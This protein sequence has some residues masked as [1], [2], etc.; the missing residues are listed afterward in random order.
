MP[1]K[2][3]PPTAS[4][5]RVL[6]AAAIWIAGGHV[7]VHAEWTGLEALIEASRSATVEMAPTVVSPELTVKGR[8]P[9]P[10]PRPAPFAA[11]A[12]WPA[13]KPAEVGRTLALPVSGRPLSVQPLDDGR[14]L[15]G[16]STVLLAVAP[17]GA[18][19]AAVVL[20]A[21]ARNV[22]PDQNGERLLVTTTGD[23]PFFVLDARTLKVHSSITGDYGGAV[24]WWGEMSGELLLVRETLDFS[25]QL[26]N[27][28]FTLIETLPESGGEPKPLG[29]PV[30]LFA[31]AG[32]VAPLG[33]FWA[34]PARP[35]QVDP[36]PGPL[37]ALEGT[38]VRGALIEPSPCADTRPAGGRDGRLYWIRT[39]EHGS[40]SGRLMTRDPS[41]G[42]V[43]R[44]LTP[45]ATWLL[46]VSP[47]GNH[48]AW[49]A[50][51]DG[52]AELRLSTA[53]ELA[54]VDSGAVAAADESLA[55]AWRAANRRMADAFAST[56][57]ADDLATTGPTPLLT[58]R[59]TWEDVE[60]MGRA[61]E[62]ALQN[63]FHLTAGERSLLPVGD[64]LL[65][66]SAGLVGDGPIEVLAVGGFVVREAR[67]RGIGT[68]LPAAGSPSLSATE[69]DWAWTDE[70]TMTLASPWVIAR[71][72]LDRKL[73]PGWV[74]AQLESQ[75]NLPVIWTDGFEGPTRSLAGEFL[76]GVA[77]VSVGEESAIV[78][79]EALERFPDC[80]VC[81]RELARRGV[82]A[83]MRERALEAAGHLAARRPLSAEAFALLAEALV[84]NG[85]S[86]QGR[87]AMD[88]ALELSPLDPVLRFQSASMSFVLGDLVRARREFGEALILPGG[89]A[90]EGLVRSRERLIDE[91]IA[92][93]PDP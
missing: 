83:G 25:G 13:P 70:T 88:W 74:I 6:F 9:R 7:P 4:A 26:E 2:T 71:E 3:M 75:G 21:G 59:P 89:G 91:T 30:D 39:R 37:V 24:A 82:N 58:D 11:P 90:L 53:E 76:L 69:A 44:Q 64:L 18:E 55:T 86:E 29:W 34:T 38:K 62:Q 77:G 35:W 31:K 1:T 66:R 65:S 15:V 84:S 40:N 54:R 79:S 33:V 81:A 48:V 87:A 16:D 92:K 51:E 28:I 52:P 42:A 20:Q 10:V 50:G 32:T 36:M 68:N 57:V 49:V 85:E 93:V 17:D 22:V 72:C 46:G 78:Y 56:S 61:F 45:G 80:D 5:G 43:A 67:R 8:M 27:R 41:E 12:G 60:I 14:I 47:S 73:S 23:V 19:P 63:D